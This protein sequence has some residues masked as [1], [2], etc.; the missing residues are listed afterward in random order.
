MIAFNA[1]LSA[2]VRMVDRVHRHAAHRRTPPMPPGSPRFAVRDVLVVE[3]TDLAYRGHAIQTE[4]SNFTRRQL[5]QRNIAFL[6]EQLR[7]AA[8][9]ANDLGTLAGLQLQ[10]VQL[11]SGRDEPDRQQRRRRRNRQRS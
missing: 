6:A 7:R 5:D 10:V 11:R 9:G 8:R 3:V 1:S 4:F 2:A